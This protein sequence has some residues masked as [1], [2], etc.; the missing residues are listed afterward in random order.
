M[1]TWEYAAGLG[2]EVADEYRRRK[3]IFGI[4]G[5]PE[6]KAYQIERLIK[7]GHS[8]E[9]FGRISHESEGIQTDMLLRVFDS[10]LDA[11]AKAQTADEINKLG[12]S[13]YDIREF[14]DRLRASC[15]GRWWE[16]ARVGRNLEKLATRLG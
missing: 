6:D 15:F 5:L 13:S 7:S 14:P 9:V 2:Q 10:A 16:P 12:V 1:V 8:V 4:E 11:V 3:R